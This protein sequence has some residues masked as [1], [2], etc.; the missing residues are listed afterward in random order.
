M[1]EVA[2]DVDAADLYAEADFS[3]LVGGHA[4]RARTFFGY[5]ERQGLRHVF[6]EG[7]DASAFDDRL[8]AVT[9][10]DPVRARRVDPLLR[11]RRRATHLA[12]RIRSTARTRLRP[13]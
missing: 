7:E 8:A 12:R 4:A 6:Q 2:P 3:G 11:T 10:P 1:S 9:F 5:L 13:A